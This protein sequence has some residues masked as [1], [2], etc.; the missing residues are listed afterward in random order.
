MNILKT[1]DYSIFKNTSNRRLI[2]SHINSLVDDLKNDPTAF[3]TSPIVVNSEF[4]IIDGQ[5]RFEASKLAK[6]HVYYIV[7]Q[8]VITDEDIEKQIQ[9]R[10]VHQASWKIDDYV[11]V[12]AKNGKQEYKFLWDLYDKYRS[13][14][15]ISS[16]YH[17]CHIDFTGIKKKTKNYSLKSGRMLISNKE[18]V[19]EF[20]EKL[21]NDTNG[22]NIPWKSIRLIYSRRYLR[23]LFEIYLQKKPRVSYEIFMRRLERNS[24]YLKNVAGEDQALECITFICNKV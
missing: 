13:I 14:F 7:D 20:I 10:N 1:K 24:G 16:I 19:K 9:I 11:E 23:S 4:I 6:T 18:D 5:H 8:N 22:L 2:Q 15:T 21:A 3:R 12:Y 17:I